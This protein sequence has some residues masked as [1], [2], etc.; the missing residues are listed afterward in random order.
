MGFINNKLEAK[1]LM[2]KRVIAENLKCDKINHQINLDE[3]EASFMVIN[4]LRKVYINV[5]IFGE[6]DLGEIAKHAR[7]ASKHLGNKP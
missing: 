1:C 2:A 4:G 5:S 3:L 7:E 6:L